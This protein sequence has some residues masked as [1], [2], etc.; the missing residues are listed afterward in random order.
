MAI[1][2]FF[3]ILLLAT[4]IFIITADSRLLLHQNLRELFQRSGNMEEGE[5]KEFSAASNKDLNPFWHDPRH[6]K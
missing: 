1:L 4:G 3:V 6:N 2:K 5:T